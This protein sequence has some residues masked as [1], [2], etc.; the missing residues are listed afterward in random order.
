MGQ[1]IAAHA[2][3]VQR[4]RLGGKWS[5]IGFQQ[6]NDKRS[7]LEDRWRLR[8]KSFSTTLTVKDT[9]GNIFRDAKEILSQWREYFED[10]LNQVKTNSTDTCDIR[11]ILV[12]EKSSK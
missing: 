11:L 2:E 6:F 4:K 5:S 7:I 1:K 12:K 10:F 3:K 8:G 9:A